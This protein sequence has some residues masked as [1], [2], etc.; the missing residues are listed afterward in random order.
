M[1]T[2][3]WESNS[4]FNSVFSPDVAHP[5]QLMIVSII[6]LIPNIV[7]WWWILQLE[8]PLVEG[9]NIIQN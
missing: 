9:P 5:T 4:E 7:Q 2:G 1:E 6:S 8:K 3:Q